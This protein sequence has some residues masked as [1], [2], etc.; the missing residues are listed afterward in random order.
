MRDQLAMK[1]NGIEDKITSETRFT[2]KFSYGNDKQNLRKYWSS[3]NT[4][5]LLEKPDYDA[6]ITE[7]KNKIPNATNLVNKIDYVRKIG[8][9]ENKIID[10][11][12]LV[13]ESDYD[14]KL[15]NINNRVTSNKK[16]EAAKTVSYHKISFTSKEMIYQE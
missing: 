11:N 15:G 3:H 4:V 7:I 16:V 10:T 1:V 6:K 13:K 2:N 9:I 8:D 14:E 5:T 12:Y